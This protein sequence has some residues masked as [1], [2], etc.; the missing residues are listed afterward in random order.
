MITKCLFLKDL[1]HFLRHLWSFLDVMYFSA[2]RI[3]LGWGGRGRRKKQTAF[4]RHPQKFHTR[5]LSSRGF[6][7]CLGGDS[8]VLVSR[9]R[10]SHLFSSKIILLTGEVHELWNWDYFPLISRQWDICGKMLRS[11]LLT[12]KCLLCQMARSKLLIYLALLFAWDCAGTEWLVK[13][14]PWLPLENLPCSRGEET[15]L[16]T[17]GREWTPGRWCKLLRVH[18]N[19]PPFI[20]GAFLARCQ[21]PD[22]ISFDPHY[23][24]RDLSY[25]QHLKKAFNFGMILDLQKHCQDSTEISYIYLTVFLM[26]TS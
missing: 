7:F 5:D 19:E 4:T 12:I 22:I 21:I 13:G 20:E 23:S 10:D 24:S 16:L 3:K 25:Y 14:K 11:G 26:L 8:P 9:D 2:W 18:D 15:H 6:G 17:A 1:G